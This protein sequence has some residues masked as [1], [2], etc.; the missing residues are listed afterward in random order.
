MPT[1]LDLTREE[2]KR[3]LGPREEREVSPKPEE[4]DRGTRKRLLS[5]VRRAAAMLKERFGVRRVVLF[6]SL[7]DEEWFQED[8]DVDIAVEGLA[9]KDYWDAWELLE[10][11][12]RERLVDL[13]E[14][15]SA[16]VGL[17]QAIERYGIEL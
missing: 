13:V 8:S 1:A 7:A 9:P 15:E 5:L 12:I 11:V 4:A 14:I 10:D 16:G 6:G 2:W 17:R 3:Y